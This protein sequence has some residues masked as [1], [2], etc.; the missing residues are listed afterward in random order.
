MLQNDIEKQ[1]NVAICMQQKY[2][3]VSTL[4]PQSPKP[5][6]AFKAQSLQSPPK[7]AKIRHFIVVV[8]LSF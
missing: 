3:L 1:R 7:P 6:K 4:Q 2:S 8:N 5:K